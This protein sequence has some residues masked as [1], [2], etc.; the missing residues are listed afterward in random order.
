[1]SP[2]YLLK[3]ALVSGSSP[4]TRLW[5]PLYPALVP[6]AVGR[7]MGTECW[8]H[9]LGPILPKA[10]Q[11]HW[12]PTGAVLTPMSGFWGT[13]GP[14]PPG[15]PITASNILE[16]LPAMPVFLPHVKAHGSVRAGTRTGL[17]E[18]GEGSEDGRW[19][20]G[21]WERTEGLREGRS[22]T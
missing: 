15:R 2:G 7:T 16:E 22:G 17:D 1:M 6:S 3:L 21:G 4:T 20:G 8:L 5:Q 9:P 12:I 11:P 13:H 10:R 14:A 19:W 18:L